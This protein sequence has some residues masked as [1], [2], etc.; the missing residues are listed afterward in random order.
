MKEKK[1]QQQ[2][3]NKEKGGDAGERLV[4]LWD[5]VH[6]DVCLR[7]GLEAACSGWSGP[8]E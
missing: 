3:R 7:G 1:E 2:R 6:M 5:A 4:T 8:K